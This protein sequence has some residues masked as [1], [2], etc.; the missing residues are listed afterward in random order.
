LGLGFSD[1]QV[2]RVLAMHPRA[3]V[4]ALDGDNAGQHAAVELAACIA[5]RGR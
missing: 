3:P 1:S 5:R 4:I 2:D